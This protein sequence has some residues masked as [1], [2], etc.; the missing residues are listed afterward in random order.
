[1]WTIKR[2]N[3]LGFSLI[4]LIMVIVILGIISAV[5]IP[6]FFDKNAFEQRAF[7]EDTLNA[8]RFAKKQA[9]ASGCNIRVSFSSTG[10]S[11]VHAD[12][13][14]ANSFNNALNV[15]Q[16]NSSSAYAAS[17]PNINLTAT[18]SRTQFD[19]LGRANQNN[20]IT[21]GS[22]TI[23]IVATTGFIYDSTP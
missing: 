21:I 18:N 8:I 10:Y 13:C 16:P 4:E 19:A 6:R 17:N 7:F 5:A 9:I 20:Q 23:S 12:T 3:Q 2:Q 14:K 15:K 1:M 11:L 22:R